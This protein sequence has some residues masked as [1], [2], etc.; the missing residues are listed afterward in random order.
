MDDSGIAALTYVTSDLTALQR[1]MTALQASQAEE[2]AALQMAKKKEL[3]E[4]KDRIREEMA[5]LQTALQTKEDRI[6]ML[7]DLLGGGEFF[8]FEEA[9]KEAKEAVAAPS[10]LRTFP[11]MGRTKEATRPCL[12]S[13]PARASERRLQGDCRCDASNMV[14]SAHWTREDYWGFVSGAES[15]AGI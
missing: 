15:H 4:L 6:R 2:M 12:S 14:R 7:E 3:A 13:R 9:E 5:A 1:E 8:E 11:K 10:R